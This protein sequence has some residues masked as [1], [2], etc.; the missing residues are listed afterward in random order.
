MMNI[1]KDL[2]LQPPDD[3]MT[4][5]FLPEKNVQDV[6]DV[7]WPIAEWMLVSNI[8]LFSYKSYPSSDSLLLIQL[9]FI[10]FDGKK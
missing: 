5:K 6:N 10:F 3:F 2:K 7:H 9:C 1:F 4:E 8:Y